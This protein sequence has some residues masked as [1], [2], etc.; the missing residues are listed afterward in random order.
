MLYLTPLLTSLAYLNGER[1]VASATIPQ[2][3]DYLQR[4]LEEC[5]Q[6]YPW[7]FARA[8]ATLTLTSGIATLPSGFDIGHK[9]KA[10]YYSDTDTEQSMEEIDYADKS[11]SQD[12]KKQFWLEPVEGTD[13]Y[14][15][16]TKETTPSQVVVVYQTL[17]P[18]INATVGTPYPRAQ[19]LTLGARR[20]IKL[21][22]NPD[23]DISQDEALFR[24]QLDADIAAYQIPRPSAAIKSIQDVQ[25]SHTGDD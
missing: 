10:S 21:G 6:A 17:P 24:Q 13:T 3:T 14:T 20:F 16:R 15:L 4:T 2:R 7:S 18:T 12:G 1:S 8:T 5:Y 11:A 22:Q 19:T 23:A 25:G 9:V